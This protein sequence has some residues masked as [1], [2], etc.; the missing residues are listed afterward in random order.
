[1]TM[2]IKHSLQV[3]A[4]PVE[5]APGVTRRW[6]WSAPDGAPTFALRLF[7]VQAAAATPYHAHP[8]EH[9]VYIL[10]GQAK[11]RGETQ[12]HTLGPGDTA[13]VLPNESHQFVN[14][15][16]EVLRLLCGIPLPRKSVNLTVQVSLY[17]LRQSRLGPSIDRA[18]ELWRSRGLQIQ[19]GPMST[20]LAGDDASVWAAV[21]DAFA[22]AAAEGEC[23]MV[24]TA[25]NACP[26]PPSP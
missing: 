15:G 4:E 10:S 20:L 14:T 22:V 21:R 11:L 13:L 16:A 9:Q 23:T 24:V 3:P 8:Y 7:E 5:N 2:Q 17:P 12:E 18:L 26:W 1:M 6:L 19:P 25:S